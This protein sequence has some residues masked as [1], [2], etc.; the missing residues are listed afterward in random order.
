MLLIFSRKEELK[1]R[2]HLYKSVNCSGPYNV[3]DAS[4]PFAKDQKCKHG[5]FILVF[6]SH[7][8]GAELLPLPALGYTCRQLLHFQK[9]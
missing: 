2:E 9:V 4:V 7:L 3:G 5:V 1:S 6:L 8:E